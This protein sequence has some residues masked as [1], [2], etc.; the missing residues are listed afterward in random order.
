VFQEHE[1]D[2]GNTEKQDEPVKNQKRG[3]L[4]SVMIIL[5]PVK[6]QDLDRDDKRDGAIVCVEQNSKKWGSPKEVF[7]FCRFQILHEEP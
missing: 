7:H 5:Y 3:K 4:D 1:E 2:P 6:P